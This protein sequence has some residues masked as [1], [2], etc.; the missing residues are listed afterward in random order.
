MAITGYRKVQNAS[1]SKKSDA[2]CSQRFAWVSSATL[3]TE[4][5][6][7]A[8]LYQVTPRVECTITLQVSFRL[9]NF[10]WMHCSYSRNIYRGL[11][12]G[13]KL[14]VTAVSSLVV[15]VLMPECTYMTL[16][17]NARLHL[18]LLITVFFPVIWW[19]SGKL[20]CT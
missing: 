1:S 10:Q 19:Q 4:G 17:T 18:T 7:T 15:E 14:A 6:T 2:S 3:S 12:D 16:H 5:A 20:H 11:V 9:I 13:T 8:H